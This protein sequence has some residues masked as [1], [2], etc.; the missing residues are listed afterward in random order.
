M[1]SQ[2]TNKYLKLSNYTIDIENFELQLQTHPDYP[3]IKSITDTFDYFNIENLVAKVPK[4]AL[5]KLPKYF[6]AL[7]KKDHDSKLF[8]AEKKKNRMTVTDENLNKQTLNFDDFKESWD[9]TI[10]AIEDNKLESDISSSSNFKKIGFLVFSII[11]LIN[12]FNFDK[13]EVFIYNTLSLV[14]FFISYFIVEEAFG[15]HNKTVAKVCETVSKA[16]GCSGVINHKKGKL[17]NT[18]SLSDASIVYF[19]INLLTLIGTGFSFSVLFCISVFSIPIVLITLYYQA[20]ILKQW[21]ALC[22][23]ISIVLIM[24]FLVLWVAFEGL[25]FDINFLL[26]YLFTTFLVVTVWYNLKRLW[27]QN[28]KL[29]SVEI[30][31]LKFKRNKE[32]FDTLL[33]KQELI[34]NKLIAKENKIVFGSDNPLLTIDA[35][36]NPLCGFCVASFQTYFK[37]LK[38]HK[39]VQ[40][41]FVFNVPF[42]DINNTAT[43]IVV[44]VLDIYLNNSKERALDALND[45]YEERSFNKWQ[46]YYKISKNIDDN[47]LTILK[48]H[49]NWLQIN[50]IKHTPATF[51]DNYYFPAEYNINDLLLF[52]DDMLL[53]PK[54]IVLETI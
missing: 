1:K 34:N 32:L 30:E 35:V 24:Q 8:L 19:I 53:E 38:T 14:G 3:S 11:T 12:L 10:I 46:G 27:A 2:I 47:I 44:T 6:I 9:G 36:T 42:E 13:I 48:E 51:V 41:N 40:I 37:L 7:L 26:K 39:D 25:Y 43:Q 29:A 28:S 16:N 45:W 52:V 15:I 21:C 5:E 49:Q 4:E 54:E 20:F 31:F 50:S 23:G 18:I 33:I 22:L 17:F